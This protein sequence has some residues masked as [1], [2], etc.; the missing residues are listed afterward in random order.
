MDGLGLRVR[1]GVTAGLA[2]LVAC[3]GVLAACRGSTPT[4]V[5]LTPD[6]ALEECCG[7]RITLIAVTA[8]GGM[9]D[10][11]YKVL[12]PVKAKAA[13]QDQANVPV[14]IAEDGTR[15]PS[16]GLAEP[17]QDPVEG[18]VY[19]MLYPNTRGVVRPGTRVT[20]VVGEVQLEPWIAQ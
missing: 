8:S 15:L 17:N 13:L 9:V 7:I 20:V 19:Y 16:P 18:R 14:L 2:L 3:L 12:D 5:P 1:R 6:R 4:P 11:R 10:L